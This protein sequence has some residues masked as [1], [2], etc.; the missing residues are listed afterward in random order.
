MSRKDLAQKRKD[1]IK[2][3]SPQLKTY[4][5]ILDRPPG[6][7]T[8]DECAALVPL[9]MKET[10]FLELNLK[11][12][13]FL[14]ITQIAESHSYIPSD[15]KQCEFMAYCVV[16]VGA[17]KLSVL[18][19]EGYIYLIVNIYREWVEVTIL[20]PGDTYSVEPY[21][22]NPERVKLESTTST[23]LFSVPLRRMQ[24]LLS[25]W[26]KESHEKASEFLATLPGISECDANE[27]AWLTSHVMFHFVG[28]DTVLFEE[29]DIIDLNRLIPIIKKGE[30]KL[31]KHTETVSPS[32][33][34]VVHNNNYND[35]NDLRRPESIELCKLGPSSIFIDSFTLELWGDEISNPKLN[36]KYSIMLRRSC[37]LVS[38]CPT[39]VG[40]MSQTAFFYLS[41]KVRNKLVENCIIH[42]PTSAEIGRLLTEHKLWTQFKDN[43]INDT[44]LKAARE[45]QNELPNHPVVDRDGLDI[46]RRNRLFGCNVNDLVD[47]KEEKPIAI[48]TWSDIYGP[49]IQVYIYI[50]ILLLCI[51]RWLCLFVNHQI[52][53]H[54][55]KICQYQVVNGLKLHLL[56]YTDI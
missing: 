21:I 10:I 9:L 15:L 11:R 44:L 29:N 41:E 49:N 14:D 40:W 55:L 16:F 53:V 31:I 8:R 33:T 2:M 6:T 1:R 19:D 30:V 20:Y 37:T 34:H 24:Q 50:I 4:K 36:P 28:Y 32:A 23:T 46:D 47:K 12:E 35:I 56:Y 27:L 39:E 18:S 25:Y 13:H 3:F 51:I 17:V 42:I 45:H 5:S 26:G 48:S 38:T 52:V 7:R 43:L 22:D 54:S